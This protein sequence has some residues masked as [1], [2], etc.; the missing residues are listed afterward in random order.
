MVQNT[1][2]NTFEK[3]VNYEIENILSQKNTHHQNL[4]KEE[5]K[6]LQDLSNNKDFVIKKADKGGATVV[7]GYDQYIQE[8]FKQLGDT[9]FYMPLTSNPI[10]ILTQ[11]VH[12]MLLQ[13]VED[14]L[15]STQEFDFLF[16]PNPRMATFYLLPKVHK[17][18][19]NPPGRP[20]ISGNE[21]LMEPISK[22]VDYFIKPLLP[23]LPA[24]I[25]DTTDVLCKI[26]EHKFIGP[27]SLLVTMD[28]EALYTNIEH[29]QGLDALRH[30][31][32]KRPLPSNS[33][34]PTDFLVKLTEWTLYN[35][36]FLFQD[37]IF[38][39]VKGCAMGACFSPSYA[40]LFMGKWEE[41][42]VFNETNVFRDKIIWWARYIDDVILWWKGTEEELM[43]FHEYL[44]AANPNVRLSLE[45]DVHKI[46]FLDLEIY[47][48]EEG[49]LHTTI[50][51]K[52]SHKNTLLHAKSFHSSTLIKN[53][54]FGQF[55]RLRRIC[56][57]DH[58]FNMK[59]K[60]MYGRFRERGY[61]AITLDRALER[62]T[63]LE[64]RSLLQRKPAVLKKER[65][66][67]STRYSTEAVRIRQVIRKNWDLF[68][69]DDILRDIFEEPPVFSFR[70]APTL[71]DRLVHSH[72]PAREQT[73]WLP[74]VPNG[75]F[76]CGH[77]KQCDIVT[78]VKGF[79]HPG[80]QRTYL[81]KHFINCKT[82]FV[83]YIL[84]CAMCDAF[85][86]GRTKRRFQDRLAE[87][88]YA[89]RVGNGDYAMVKHFNEVHDGNLASFSALGID[90]VPLSSRRGDRQ[91]ILN[92]KESRWIH[93]LNAMT[94]PGLNDSIDIDRKSVV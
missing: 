53:I 3:K 52:E 48:D 8:A 19:I 42:F 94:F 44:N 88:R 67:F 79:T 40:G 64:R 50:F 47:K 33:F 7:W 63:S 86:V 9:T 16:K 15:I 65:V 55:Q 78:K 70:R 41:D 84:K 60:E 35:N 5:R 29:T 56:D 26:D 18:M 89:A 87:H 32:D 93:R 45:Y 54:P 23:T 72:L 46:H 77:C 82:V 22:Y 38:K 6:I 90:H 85:Y 91:R 62:A 61:Q 58:E 34:P 75:T 69:C 74:K 1:T 14:N 57:D 28:V 31:L 2:L 17:D 11:D 92:Q 24:Y 81:T 21:T 25:Q 49:F 59:S 71:N 20:V 68:R 4:T 30:F 10:Q 12:K 36:V 80:T 39:Q 73:T 43:S 66:Y 83:I 51:R 13:A 76:K 37:K 27:E